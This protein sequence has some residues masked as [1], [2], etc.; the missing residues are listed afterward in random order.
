VNVYGACPPWVAYVGLAMA[1]AVLSAWPGT[2]R[3]CRTVGWVLIV[4]G[5]VAILTGPII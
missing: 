1:M 4:T 5:A 2:S 3:R